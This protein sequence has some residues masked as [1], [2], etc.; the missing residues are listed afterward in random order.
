MGTAPPC[1]P[2]LLRGMRTALSMPNCRGLQGQLAGRVP[3]RQS[4][5][6]RA[7][8]GQPALR[9]VGALVGEVAKPA[10]GVLQRRQRDASGV[11]VVALQRQQRLAL[12]RGEPSAQIPRPAAVGAATAPAAV[13][14]R[15]AA[16]RLPQAAL[17][18]ALPGSS[19]GRLA[20][21]D[22]PVLTHQGDDPVNEQAPNALVKLLGMELHSVDVLLCVLHGHE[23][24]HAVHCR[25]DEARRRSL[26]K[27]VI[28]C[29]LREGV[30]KVLE[31]ARGHTQ[32]SH[33]FPLTACMSAVLVGDQRPAIKHCEE[34]HA[35]AN[36]D[37]GR[38]G[39]MQQRRSGLGHV[40]AYVHG[41][42]ED[43]RAAA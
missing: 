2:L 35:K 14:A 20:A 7:A 8:E 27:D 33:L 21:F 31:Q 22:P 39:E 38:V 40:G 12:R 18:R 29:P 32:A 16:D 6:A 43:D 4:G 9:P 42:G 11:A 30:R 19:T 5:L 24:A 36:A 26:H 17:G 37:H 28:A 41:L 25:G 23:P 13:V 10:D 15:G 1:A 3:E 34:L